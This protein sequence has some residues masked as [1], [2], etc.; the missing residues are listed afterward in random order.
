MSLRN[1]SRRLGFAALSLALG[2]VGAQSAQANVYASRLRVTQPT[3]TDPFD[4]NFFDGSGARIR[5][6]VGGFR[7]VGVTPE[8]AD[9]VVVSVKLGGATIYSVTMMNVPSGDT[10]VVW[11]GGVNGGNIPAPAGSYTYEVTVSDA[12][13]AT[14]TETWKFTDVDQVLL[15]LSDRAVASNNFPSTPGFGTSIYLESGTG[16]HQISVLRPDGSLV[17]E[18]LVNSTV[19]NASSRSPWFSDI[20]SDGRYYVNNSNTNNSDAPLGDGE[21]LVINPDGTVF[22]KLPVPTS[23]TLRG[24]DVTVTATDTTLTYVDGTVVKRYINGVTTTLGTF[25][26]PYLRD[27]TIDDA[28]NIYVTGGS[29]SGTGLFKNL[30]KLSPAGTLIDSAAAT[31]D[32]V[33]AT[34]A[35]RGAGVAD[36][37]I[38]VYV[39]GLGI[40]QVTFTTPGTPGTVSAIL[41]SNATSTSISMQIAADA[42]GNIVYANPSNEFNNL[43]SPGDGQNSYTTPNPTGANLVVVGVLP[44]EL[45]STGAVRRGSDVVLSWATATEK[46]NAGFQVE[47]LE[48]ANW[49]ALGFVAGSGTTT[50]AKSY[51]Y[52]ENRAPAGRL[53]YRLVQQDLDGTAHISPT[54]TLEAAGVAPTAFKLLG[55]SPNPFNPTASIRFELPAASRVT[56]VVYN[57]AG[58]KVATLLDGATLEAGTQAVPFDA[59]ALPSGMYLYRLTAGQQVA[60]GR[61]T[62]M[63]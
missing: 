43:V 7:S 27:L 24:L 10:S 12:G 48:G 36:D 60:S 1:P 28:G 19:F 58:Q 15:G 11:N 57:S 46:N 54:I 62:L 42:A 22:R 47:R 9:Q 30:Y 3:S 35:R 23:Q 21:I 16:R 52:T 25:S 32:L 14:P 17:S 4:G 40:S 53:S 26:R 8:T 31:A 59:S 44:V 34:V 13:Y 37:R 38:Y 56:L 6:N 50:E 61:M 20:G 45:T 63:K 18:L 2:A 5:F 49:K 33:S 55:A 51:G 29:G 41:F 39:R